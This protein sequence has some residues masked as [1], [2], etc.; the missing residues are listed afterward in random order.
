[1]GPIRFADAGVE[2]NSVSHRYRDEAARYVGVDG[3]EFCAEATVIRV[4]A[5][6]SG[7]PTR[8]IAMVRTAC[9]IRAA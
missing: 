7:A 3:G 4:R 1:M 9:G 5:Q 2:M 6:S 8:A